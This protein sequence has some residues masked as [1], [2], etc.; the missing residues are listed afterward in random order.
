MFREDKLLYKGEMA[1][2]FTGNCAIVSDWSN[3]SWI[4]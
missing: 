4:C 2:E 3:C 1:Y